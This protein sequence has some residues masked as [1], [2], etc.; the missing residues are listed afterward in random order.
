MTP[1][2]GRR[3]GAGRPRELCGRH[4]LRVNLDAATVDKLQAWCDSLGLTRSEA[5]RYLIRVAPDPDTN[6]ETNK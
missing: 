6:T 3:K 4:P 1:H 5:V 2:G